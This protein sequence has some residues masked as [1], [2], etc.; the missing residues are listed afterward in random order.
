MK[1]S[2]GGHVS[3]RHVV[4]HRAAHVI[5]TEYGMLGGLVAC[6]AIYATSLVMDG[7]SG[8]AARPMIGIS[9][10]H[11]AARRP[12]LAHFAEAADRPG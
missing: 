11:P 8:Q 10:G 4:A 12:H 2:S 6:G 3:D 1:T 9:R 7:Y 5:A